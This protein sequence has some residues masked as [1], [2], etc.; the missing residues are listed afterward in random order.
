MKI[1]QPLKAITMPKDAR[2]RPDPA[3][4]RLTENTVNS[5]PNPLMTM[6]ESINNFLLKNPPTKA[7]AKYP[8][9]VLEYMIDCIMLK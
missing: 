6:L 5:N 3:I 1:K 7:M 4:S 8:T 2:N 9:I